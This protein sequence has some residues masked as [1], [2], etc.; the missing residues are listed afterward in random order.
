MWMQT[1]SHL[2]PKTVLGY[3]SL[4]RTRILPTF[5]PVPIGEIRP[6]DVRSWPADL[7]LAGLS[8]SRRRSAYH[9]LSA[10]LRTAVEDGRLAATPCV[11]LSV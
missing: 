3:E 4:L 2:K 8:A 10:I 5:G 11:A 6:L 7:Q 9:L 1:V